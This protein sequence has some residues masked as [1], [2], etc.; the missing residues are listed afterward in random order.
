[1]RAE[2]VA[3]TFFEDLFESFDCGRNY[4]CQKLGAY[5]VCGKRPAQTFRLMA[6]R[7][8]GSLG[9]MRLSESSTGLMRLQ[10]RFPCRIRN[11]NPIL[12]HGGVSE[13]GEGWCSCID[14]RLGMMPTETGLCHTRW[15]IESFFLERWVCSLPCR[16]SLSTDPIQV[17]IPWVATEIQAIRWSFRQM[18]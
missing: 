11:N 2:V 6:S 15:V 8:R 16:P 4:M 1:M 12:P 9:W 3:L 10:S 18:N 7:I 14:V 5:H 17:A 13:G